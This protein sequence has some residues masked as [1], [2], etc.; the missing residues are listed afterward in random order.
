MRSRSLLGALGSATLLSACG[1]AQAVITAELEVNDPDQGTVS[2]PISDLEIRLFPFDR[3]AVF[4]SLTQVASVPEPAIPDSVLEAQAQVQA[5]QARWRNL[6]ARWNTLR[7]TLQTISDAMDGLS[8]GQARYRLLFNDFQDIEDQYN[9]VERQRDQAFR[10]FTSLQEQS[11]AA[12]DAIRIRRENWADEAFADI[13]L[14]IAAKLQ[15]SGKQIMYD[16]TDANGITQF[17]VPPGEWWASARYEL[18]FTELYWNE[19]IDLSRGEPFP[20][21]LTRAN[22]QERPK[23]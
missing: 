9:R 20:L 14:V 18:P 4:D 15:A 21:T 13:G 6:E 11:I 8:R 3:D 23:L 1:G 10:D 2:R 16:T 12:A 19:R 7:D 22:A 5:A 17:E